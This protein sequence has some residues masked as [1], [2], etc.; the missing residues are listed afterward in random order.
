[1]WQTE[2]ENSTSDKTPK[3]IHQIWYQGVPPPDPIYRK[4]TTEWKRLHPNYE[5]MFWEQTLMSD[6]VKLVVPQHHRFWGSM[7]MIEQIDFARYAILYK[8]GG[9]YSDLDIIP[10]KNF[11]DL[12]DLS[13]PIM[14]WE[15][16]KHIGNALMMSPP[17]MSI[18]LNIMDA[19]VAKYNRSSNPVDNTGP[20]ILTRWYEEHKPSEIALA[21]S[22]IFYPMTFNIC[23]I[24]CVGSCNCLDPG[25]DF[26]TASKD[27]CYHEVNEDSYCC[28]LWTTRWSSWSDEEIYA[29]LAFVLLVVI[30]LLAIAP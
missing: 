15:P 14:G 24:A 12:V 1:M 25:V 5:Y 26:K 28:H 4:S 21:K 2:G 29:L 20:A 22:H 27:C 30:L 17:N 19:I 13:R 23:K 16:R 7:R 10:I 18:W 6:I 8:I 11:D 9:I 3:I